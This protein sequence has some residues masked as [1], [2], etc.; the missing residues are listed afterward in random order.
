MKL[1]PTVAAAIALFSIPGHGLSAQVVI[2][3]VNFTKNAQWIEF[4]NMGT[5]TTSLGNWSIYQA[6]KTPNRFNDYWW[7]FPISTQIKAGAYLRV[8]WGAAIQ[9]NPGPLLPLTDLL[10]NSPAP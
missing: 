4:F 1:L 6:T 3:E 8:N 10:I 5:T 2:N 7:P 9:A